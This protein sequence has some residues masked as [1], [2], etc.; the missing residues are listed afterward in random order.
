MIFTIIISLILLGG[1]AFFLSKKK[2]KETKTY[3]ELSEVSPP[4]GTENFDK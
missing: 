3:A 1:A 2:S 4:G